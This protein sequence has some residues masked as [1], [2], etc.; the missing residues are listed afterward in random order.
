MR[1]YTVTIPFLGQITLVR[2]PTQFAMPLHRER[3]TYADGTKEHRVACG[4]LEMYMT[5]WPAVQAG[6]QP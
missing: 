3:T 6:R 4:R 2:L 5:L 1:T